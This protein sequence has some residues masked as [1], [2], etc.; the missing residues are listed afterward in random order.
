MTLEFKHRFPKFINIKAGLA[1]TGM[2]EN[3]SVLGS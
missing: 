2:P 3:D 1:F